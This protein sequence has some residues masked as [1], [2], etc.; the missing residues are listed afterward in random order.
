MTACP[1]YRLVTGEPFRDARPGAENSLLGSDEW[2]F[3]EICNGDA[4]HLELMASF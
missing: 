2:T 1:I 4:M 3:G